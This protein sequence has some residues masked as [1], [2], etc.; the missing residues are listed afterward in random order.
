MILSFMMWKW[1][2][3]ECVKS[4]KSKYRWGTSFHESVLI[5]KEKKKT[6]KK[7]GGEIRFNA[8]EFMPELSEDEEY[9]EY[10]GY[11]HFHT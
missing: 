5:K 8:D 11:E 4:K 9:E 3:R 1:D 2:G 6:R 7:D 10:E